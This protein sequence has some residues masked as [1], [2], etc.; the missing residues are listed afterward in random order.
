M[1]RALSLGQYFRFQHQTADQAAGL[2]SSAGAGRRHHECRQS[3]ERQVGADPRLE[4]VLREDG[5]GDQRL[6]RRREPAVCLQCGARRPGGRSHL[7]PRARTRRAGRDS[8]VR[9]V[10]RPL[11][12]LR[13]LSQLSPL[14]L[15][16]HRNCG[17]PSM[18]A[19]FPITADTVLAALHQVIADFDHRPTHPVVGKG[20]RTYAFFPTAIT[21]NIP[22]LRPELSAA[23]RLLS[24][25]HLERVA[26]TTLGV[27]EE[28]RGA[29]IISDILLHYNLPRTLARW[30]PTG[31]P[32]E[33]A[34]PLANEYIQEGTMRVFLN[35][36][37]PGDRV[38]LVDDLISTG[39]TMVALIDAV[40]KAGAEILEIFTIGEKAENRGRSHI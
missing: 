12:V 40:R 23:V 34:V 1:L 20:G 33:V 21:D 18:H 38:L 32:G 17:I 15:R 30:S 27:G 25:L 16:D 2:A 26:E 28:D 5:D 19:D 14:A 35:G 8:L 36:V 39:G 10:Q 31:A 22:P 6:L 11:R 24:Q 9:P 7:R 4:P 13:S 29:M 37:R 3:A